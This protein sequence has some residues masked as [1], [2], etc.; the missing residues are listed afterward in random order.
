MCN[1]KQDCT[2]GSDETA[3]TCS[4]HFCP[5]Y[6]FR[7]AYG[8]CVP[9]KSRCNSVI[10]CIDG[11]DETEALCGRAPPTTTVAPRRPA[12]VRPPG[13]CAIPAIENGRVIS[14]VTNESYS[15]HQFAQNGQRLV[16]VCLDTTLV[17]DTEAYCIE[18]SL[19]SDPPRCASKARP[20]LIVVI[21]VGNGE[22]P[23][24][25]R[26]MLDVNPGH[27]ISPGDV[28]R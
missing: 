5:S 21:I 14:P 24:N 19:T 25:F 26:G 18:G 8:G 15:S 12:A 7:C 2:D 4:V 20:S 27:T 9:G 10:D 6:A 13:G 17:G 16:F 28:R 11:S 3:D 23:N 22:P 1:G